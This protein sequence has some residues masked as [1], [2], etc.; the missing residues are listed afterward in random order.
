MEK[1]CF[2]RRAGS[3]RVQVQNLCLTGRKA[4]ETYYISHLKILTVN[5]Y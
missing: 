5:A 4:S 3:L 2:T 1:N